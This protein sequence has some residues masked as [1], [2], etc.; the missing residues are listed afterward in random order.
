MNTFLYLAQSISTSPYTSSA[1]GSNLSSAEAALLGTLFIFLIIPLFLASYVV[2]SLCIMSIFKKANVPGWMA[3]VPVV[4][5]WKTFEIGGQHGWWALLML[6]PFVNIVAAVMFYIA[7][8]HIAIKLGKDGV[9]ILLG[10]FLPIVWYIWLAVDKSTWDDA[11][12]PNAP[13]RHI[14]TP[15][16]SSTQP[17]AAPTV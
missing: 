1:G 6:I 7:M 4:N 17:P 15:E 13:S 9:F 10:I 8:Y 3:W 16:V 11:A 5:N 2:M 14:A 12:S